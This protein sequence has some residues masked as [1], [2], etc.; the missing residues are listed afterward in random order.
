[1]KINKERLWNREQ[2]IGEIGRDERGGISRFAWTTEYR[3][4]ALLLID[5][6]K[7]AGLKVRV[8]T[9][10][11]IYGKYEGKEDIPP[12]L[13][14]SHLDTVPMGGKFD[15]LAGIM[16]ALEAVTTMNEQKFVP[17]RPIE[18]IAF[19][20]EEAS[21]FLGGHFGSKA[22]CGMLPDDF[23]EKTIDRN[24][25]I[26]LKQAMEEYDMGLEPDNFKGSYISKEDYF[27]FIELH[28]EQG[29]YLL[30]QNIPVA[31]VEDIAGIH[32]FY[33]TYHGVSAHAGGLA[34]E[35]R[36][37]AFQAVA[38]TA[39][40]IEKLALN[41][42]STTRGT[43]GYVSVKPNEHNIIAN[44]VT[45]SVD[46]REVDDVIWKELYDKTI[47]FVEDQCKKRGLTYEVTT[48]IS[49]APCHCDKTIKELIA[50][51]AKEEN[52]PYTNMVS[53]PAHDAMQMGR[54]FPMAMIFLRS[55]NEGVSHCP[56]EYTTKEDLA[57]GT[58][59][60]YDTLVKLSE[61]ESFN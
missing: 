31:V 9:V 30:K 44:E 33:I 52:I 25:G 8:D 53:Y 54:L 27:A 23:A 5:W 35:D 58:E 39:C 6:M 11:N 3:K 20:N 47:T 28:I 26:T 19:I 37:D 46:F 34:M 36:H 40:E 16:A 56:D 50:E 17:R 60:L 45:M 14:G 10:G 2:E 59:V 13:T 32:Q 42:G 51:S 49:T 22:I 4:A 55:S 48:T 41:S 61:L 1:M 7:Q 29:M 24:T 38:E 12:V 43:V 15:G 18:I 57:M 21:Q